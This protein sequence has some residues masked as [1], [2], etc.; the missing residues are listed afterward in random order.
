V[1][2]IAPAFFI[3][4]SFSE[5]KNSNSFLEKGIAIQRSSAISETNCECRLK[6]FGDGEN[7]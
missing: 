2:E 3:A 4:I 1:F 6:T 5:E 7:L